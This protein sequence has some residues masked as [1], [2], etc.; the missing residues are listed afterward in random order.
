MTPRALSIRIRLL[1]VPCCRWTHQGLCETVSQKSCSDFTSVINKIDAG[2][3]G[4]MFGVRAEVR[5][6]VAL[7]GIWDHNI[8]N[9]SGTDSV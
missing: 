9:Y 1:L 7:E 4:S 8:G 5:E 3:I 2:T 6:T